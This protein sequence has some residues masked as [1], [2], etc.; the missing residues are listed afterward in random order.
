M[1]DREII[2]RKVTSK[3]SKF[4]KEQKVKVYGLIEALYIV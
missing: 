2:E 1:P 3:E 4:T